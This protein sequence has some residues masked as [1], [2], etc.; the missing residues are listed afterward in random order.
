MAL[1]NTNTGIITTLDA[2]APAD[3]PEGDVITVVTSPKDPLRYRTHGCPR[4]ANTSKETK[5][6]CQ[7]R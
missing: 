5:L 6:V 3:Y 2:K 1:N 7:I 4:P